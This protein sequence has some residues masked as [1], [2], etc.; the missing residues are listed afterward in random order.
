MLVFT[1]ATPSMFVA[2]LS[3]FVKLLLDQLQDE[4][5][6][7]HVGDITVGSDL[8]H[9]RCFLRDG[10]GSVRLS[11]GTAGSQRQHNDENDLKSEINFSHYSLTNLLSLAL[12]SMF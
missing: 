11:D 9:G 6:S 8:F 12:I 1:G 10:G 5:A 4:L 7:F 2:L 3:Q